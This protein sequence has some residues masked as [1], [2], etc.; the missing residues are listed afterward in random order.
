MRGKHC[1]MGIVLVAVTAA[2]LLLLEG[3]PNRAAEEAK[4]VLPDAMYAKL[5]EQALKAAKE[6]LTDDSGRN[7]PARRKAESAVILLAAF[8]QDNLAGK[9][10]QQRA[11][12]RDEALKILSLIRSQRIQEALKQLDALRAIRSNPEVKLAKR[13]LSE[14]FSCFGDFARMFRRA[15]YGGWGIESRFLELEFSSREEGAIAA[16]DLN[17]DLL[18]TSY[19]TAV[20]AE[21]HSEFQEMRRLQNW[22]EWGDYMKVVSLQLAEATAK[23]DGVRALAEI[24]K[25]NASCATCHQAFRVPPPLPAPPAP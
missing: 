1:P 21:I 14:H 23:K 10:G 3:T 9:D 6:S 15:K 22:K 8:A 16:R 13:P 19:Q 20:M 5:V 18:L 7:A 12:L 25:L 24:S 11:T 4:S 2:C 17:E